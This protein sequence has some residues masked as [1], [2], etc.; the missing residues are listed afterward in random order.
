MIALND[1]SK[2]HEQ[3]PVLDNCSLRVHE[4]AVVVVCGPPSSDKSTLIKTI[5][6]PEPIHRQRAR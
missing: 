3:F 2:W 4:S 6:G 1:L 5:N